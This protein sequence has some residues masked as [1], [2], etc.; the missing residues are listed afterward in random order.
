M[1]DSRTD[2]AAAPD[3]DAASRVASAVA[4]APFVRIFGHADGDA[5]AAC[6]L[7]AVALRDREIPFRV[8]VSADPAGDAV[9]VETAEDDSS[10]AGATD[11]DAESRTVVVSRGQRGPADLAVPARGDRQPASV[12]AAAISRELGVDPDPVLALAGV[13]AAGETPGGAGSDDLL[14][15]AQAADLVERRPGVAVPTADLA[16]DLAHST[17]FD[18][19]FSGDGDA[20]RDLLADLGIPTDSDAEIDEEMRTA[21]ASAVAVEAATADSA[22]PQAA[23]SVGD[24]LRPYATPTAP[25][26]TLGGYAD[27]LS[28]LACEAPGAAVSLAFGA[29]GAVS[30]AVDVW[31][32]HAAAAHAALDSPT[33]GRYEGVYVLRVET[34]RPSVLPMVARLARVFRSP[35]PVALVV[36]DEP[37]DG[38]R[39][40]A[41]AATEP[42]GL[43]D[44]TATVARELAADAGGTPTQ[45]TLDVAGS[46][47]DG[48]LIAA[49]REA[50][51]DD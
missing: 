27:V 42:R 5:L 23:E 20:A 1:S 19:P 32:D 9:A 29:P 22:A 36:T 7:L 44:A 37:V 18:A 47:A 46:V 28:A 12:A 17:R 13:I 6:G 48:E 50:L 34:D 31:R 10:E 8:H 24:A 3:P 41:L 38:R 15:A 21:I 14:A 2:A 4:A 49:V 51:D 43:A 26:A 39:R 40:A 45:A 16:A 33:T 35:E 11:A 25:F 30:E